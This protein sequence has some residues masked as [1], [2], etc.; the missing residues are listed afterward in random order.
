MGKKMTVAQVKA[1]KRVPYASIRDKLRSGQLLFTSGDYMVSRLI[2]AAT[3]SPWSHVGILFR[4]EAIDRVL[5]LESVEDVGVRL[6][7]LSKYLT[8]YE[9][10]KPYQGQVVIA[11]VDGLA[12]EKLPDAARFGCDMLCRPY[13][14]S[15]IG[16][17]V[18]RIGL[19]IGRKQVRDDSYICSE[20]VYECLKRARVTI[21]YNK[22]GFVSPED[23]WRDTRVTPLHRML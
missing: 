16:R 14:S 22:K 6:A 21:R 17:I 5:L 7:P 13:D 2:Q 12:P 1:L 20:L 10:G 11:D 23:V 19:G 3:D 8:D 18:A 15:E 4:V 9:D